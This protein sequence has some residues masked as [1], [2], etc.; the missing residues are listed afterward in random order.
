MPTI[1]DERLKLWSLIGDA[2]S[3]GDGAAAKLR[4]DVFCANFQDIKD[5]V[6]ELDKFK[7]TLERE[8]GKQ[9][10]RVDQSTKTLNPLQK[11]VGL[12]SGI[13]EVEWWRTREL[14]YFL[15]RLAIAHKMFPAG[16]IDY[17]PRGREVPIKEGT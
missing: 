7:V 10:A 13:G 9:L 8:Y 11:Q 15:Y 2:M 6:K 4:M 17:R 12:G 14:Y 1:K 16:I 5:A 3:S